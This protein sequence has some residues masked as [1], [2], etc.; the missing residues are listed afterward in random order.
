MEITPEHGKFISSAEREQETLERIRERFSDPEADDPGWSS[1][2]RSMNEVREADEVL[3]EALTD[4]GE[5]INETGRR[6]D[7]IEAST[8]K[9]DERELYS[10]AERS[11]ES[12]IDSYTDAMEQYYWK[13]Q[14]RWLKSAMIDDLLRAGPGGVEDMIDARRREIESL[15][16]AGSALEQLEPGEKPRSPVSGDDSLS[17]DQREQEETGII[18]RRGMI[19]A[20]GVTA[21][22]FL[23]RR[24][25]ESGGPETK[26]D[27]D[28]NTRVSDTGTPG[29]QEFMDETSIN[30]I[31][32][33]LRQ[34]SQNDPINRDDFEGIDIRDGRYVL[35]LEGYEIDL[36]HLQGEELEIL[37][38]NDSSA[39]LYDLFEESPYVE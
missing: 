32:D 39:E 3:I 13:E 5:R 31:N 4:V 35:E 9:E 26:P 12:A 18:S 19:I 23:G 2:W 33:D 30:E 25:I 15:E 34:V 17:P 7:S 36:G 27:R 28:G 20:G 38:E 1:G 10:D 24:S 21:A 14:D 11:L 8:L 29:Y 16:E 37:L 22:Y 6:L